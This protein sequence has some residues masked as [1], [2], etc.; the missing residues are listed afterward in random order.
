MNEVHV[1]YTDDNNYQFF[2]KMSDG[3]PVYMYSPPP[4]PSREFLKEEKEKKK[5]VIDDYNK[6]TELNITDTSKFLDTFNKE[7]QREQE[8]RE[9]IDRLEENK[10]DE[11]YFPPVEDKHN[12]L[13]YIK[14]A[15]SDSIVESSSVSVDEYLGL[16]K[17][18]QQRQ[19]E[20]EER[21]KAIQDSVQ[22]RIDREDDRRSKSAEKYQLYLESVEQSEKGRVHEFEALI[23]ERE[24]E[25]L[26]AY[27]QLLASQPIIEFYTKGADYKIKSDITTKTVTVTNKDTGNERVFNYLGDLQETKISGYKLRIYSIVRSDKEGYGIVKEDYSYMTHRHM[28]YDL[29][30]GN[31]IKR[32]TFIVSKLDPASVTSEDPEAYSDGY[33]TY[34][35]ELI[36]EIVYT[37]NDPG[38]VTVSLS[39][40][41]FSPVDPD[42]VISELTVELYGAGGAGADGEISTPSRFGGAGGAYITKTFNRDQLDGVSEININIGSGV[43]SG[44]SSVQLDWDNSV[45]RPSKDTYAIVGSLTA[46]AGGGRD[47]ILTDSIVAPAFQGQPMLTFDTGYYGMGAQT[48]NYLSAAGA[49][50]LNDFNVMNDSSSNAGEGGYGA[51]LSGHGS[52][53]NN[54]GASGGDAGTSSIAPTSGLPPGAG[55]G[56]GNQNATGGNEIGADGA[57]GKAVVTISRVI[58]NTV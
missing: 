45:I 51:A 40:G 55:G 8:H 46:A 44:V 1:G 43:Y 52:K 27:D 11:T 34:N 30:N 19:E 20:E 6:S 16:F 9:Y 12:V 56:G 15:S 18:E 25:L 5:K 58:V 33:S 31:S 23:Q 38:I 13:D 17:V 53:T 36:N 42:S 32:E 37:F 39:A 54:V 49:F 28:T 14:S 2:G 21:L 7:E 29:R 22:D 10:V 57:P 47:A 50:I 35:Q 41:D 26:Q 24:K 4:P 3:T 48:E